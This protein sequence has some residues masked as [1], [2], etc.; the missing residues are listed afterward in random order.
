MLSQFKHIVM[1]K[2]KEGTSQ[3]DI[4]SILSKFLA[5]KELI[6]EIRAIEWGVHTGSSI[7]NKGFTHYFNI[8]FAGEKEKDIYQQHPAHMAFS[9]FLSAYKDDVFIFDYQSE[10]IR[11]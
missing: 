11:K 6:P 1:L 7:K 3:S 5:L 9:E 4:D 2:F 8:E 10:T